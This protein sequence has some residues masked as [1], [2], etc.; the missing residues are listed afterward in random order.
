LTKENA[1]LDIRFDDEGLSYV[2]VDGPRDFNIVCNREFGEHEIALRTRTP[3]LEIFTFSFVTGAI[4]E[5]VSM[6]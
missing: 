3:G 2:L 4:P 5:L 6:N 1:G